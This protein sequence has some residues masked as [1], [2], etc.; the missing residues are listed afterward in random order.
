MEVSAT[1]VAITTR[2]FA[3]GEK[4]RCCSA[5]D[6]RPN[7][8]STSIRLPANRPSSK[9]R[10]SRMSRSVGIKISTSPASVS[11]NASSAA[12]TAASMK[13][14]SSSSSATGRYRTSTGYNRPETSMIGAPPKCAANASVSI[15][16]DVTITFKSGRLGSNPFKYPS[17][18]S[19]FSDRSC[20]SSKMIIEYCRS[21][22][23]LWISASRIP[24]VMNFTRVSRLVSSLNRILHP[25]SRPQVTPNSSATRRDTLIA[26]T[27]LGCVHPICPFKSSPAA[28]KH[29]FGN[30]VVF[31]DPVSP[32][33]IST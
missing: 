31:P 7:K 13:C 1:F 23:S 29:I 16:A 21:I 10:V 15:V 30:C 18:K 22:G 11:I 8:A 28:S 33:K 26:A 3:P 32:A 25:T 24:S 4:I 20:A 6:C 9:S 12:A 19:M 5:D 14:G 27:R 17:K 2:R